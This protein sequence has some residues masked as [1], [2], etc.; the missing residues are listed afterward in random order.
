[1][2]PTTVKYSHM[3][4]I[5]MPD[6]VAEEKVKVLHAL[7]ATVE[8]VRPASIVDQKQVCIPIPIIC[9]KADLCLSLVC[10]EL[11]TLTL[12]SFF[13]LRLSWLESC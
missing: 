2:P 3:A 9:N 1:M 7:G 11:T 4:A 13:L 8:R 6:D 10:C 5:I 12:T